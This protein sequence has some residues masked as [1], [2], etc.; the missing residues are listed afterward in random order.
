MTY[1]ITAQYTSPAGQ[2][3]LYLMVIN[4]PPGQA[5][6]LTSF[7]NILDVRLLQ[8]GGWSVTKLDKKTEEGLIAA[9]LQGMTMENG[10]LSQTKGT[11]S[12]SKVLQVQ[13]QVVAGINYKITA[14]FT[15]SNGYSENILM[16]IYV[17]PG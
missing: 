4:V 16:V 14:Q 8:A 10:F 17:A 11:W 5:P 1:E 13:S 12:C 2:N 15:N 9:G 3:E 7:S 6:V